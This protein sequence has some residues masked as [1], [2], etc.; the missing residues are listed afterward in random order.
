[1]LLTGMIKLFNNE[2]A[3]ATYTRPSLAS[4]TS[5]RN[6]N[7]GFGFRK[8]D[9]I[10]RRPSPRFLSTGGDGSSGGSGSDESTFTVTYLD[11]LT[12]SST[13]SK[14]RI[15]PSMYIN[16]DDLY[17]RAMLGILNSDREIVS[18]ESSPR[19]LS[20]SSAP[21]HFPIGLSGGAESPRM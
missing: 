19:C 10:S 18:A 13:S 11:I 15:F 5:N 9:T 3:A 2:N 4:T 20:M 17:A 21:R 12:D 7:L 14:V 1:M 8:L 16:E 6:A